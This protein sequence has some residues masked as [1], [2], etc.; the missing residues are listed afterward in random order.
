M[1]KWTPPLTVLCALLVLAAPV[2]GQLNVTSWEESLSFDLAPDPSFSEM[3][4][5][6]VVPEPL[7]T[8]FNGASYS[9]SGGISFDP[10][11]P[12][13][14]CE[15]EANYMTGLTAFDGSAFSHIGFQFRVIETS[16]PPVVVGMVPVDVSASGSVQATGN[17][18]LYAS[19][20]SVFNLSNGQVTILNDAAFA[21]N[22]NGPASDSF[23]LS[24][25]LALA[26][27]EVMSVDLNATAA[28]AAFTIQDNIFAGGFA[29]ID[30]LIE[31][32][33]QTIPGSSASYR[34]HYEV[35][36]GSGYD[37]L[38]PTPVLETTWGRLKGL[39]Q[40]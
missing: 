7:S 8:S 9:Y 10:G 36:F 21:E 1:M 38:N 2:A 24:Q 30:H 32:A 34:D 39:Y 18:D 23:L 27:G 26:P 4:S 29:Y 5:S 22:T 15:V 28:V 35:E 12:N 3:G 19:G 17:G 37:A 40:N 20:T 16:P 14:T 13:V 33:D 11:D 25:L 6:N 31:V